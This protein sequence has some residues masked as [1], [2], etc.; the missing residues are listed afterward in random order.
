MLERNACTHP[1]GRGM[2]R[3]KMHCRRV[4]YGPGLCMQMG[5]S[6]E[7]F[8]GDFFSVGDNIIR[9]ISHFLEKPFVSHVVEKV[10]AFRVK[11]AV[12]NNAEIFKA[13]HFTSVSYPQ[14]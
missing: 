7:V 10:D 5:E 3:L 2:L 4:L 1:K 8:N 9:S 12:V 6:V 11:C 13:K 14:L